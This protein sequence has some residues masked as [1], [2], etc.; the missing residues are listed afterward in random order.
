[1]K[2]YFSILVFILNA[3]LGFS[4]SS[5]QMPGVMSNSTV[6]DRLF[7]E[8]YLWGYSTSNAVGSEKSSID[9]NAI[10]NW[11]TLGYYLS[12]S[13]DGK[14]FSYTVNK[15]TGTLNWFRRLDSLVIQSTHNEWRKAFAGSGPGFFTANGE[16]YV[17]QS[18]EALCLLQL[19]KSQPR[20]VKDVVSYKVSQHG[21]NEW[22][23]WQ[24]KN[25]DSNVVL[26][27]LVT[28][29]ETPF[30][31]VREYNFDNSGEWLVCKLAN[32][33][34]IYNLVTGA[35]RH[36][37][38]VVDY[39]FAPNGKAILLKAIE[40]SGNEITISLKYLG[41]PDWKST[42]IWSTKNER[43]DI[44][45][46]NIDNE[47]R[48][49][50]FTIQ[51]G[52]GTNIWYYNAGMDKAIVKATNGSPGIAAGLAIVS[53]VSF[54]DNGRY[55]KCFIQST[56]DS[57]KPDPDLAQ[58]EVWSH[59]DLYLQSAQAELAKQPKVYAAFINLESG[60]IM[61]LESNGKKLYLL[62][63]DF[64]VVKK[65]PTEEHGDRF[66]ETEKDVNNDSNWLVSLKDGTSKFLP[67][68]A[69]N[70]LFWFSPSGKYLVY[71]DADKGCHFF[72]YDLYTGALK[73]ISPNIPVNQL[74]LVDPYMGRK[75][76]FGNLAAWIEHDAGVLV[77]DNYD[78]WRLD[79][80]GKEPG[81]NITNGF[82]HSNNTVLNL[83]A[84][85][86]YSGNFPVIKANAPLLLQAFNRRNKFNG[87]YRKTDLSAGAPKQLCMGSYFMNAILGCHDVNL[88]NSGMAPVKANDQEIWIVQRQS[89]TE[90]P[91]YFKTTDFIN[92]K[93]LTNFQPQQYFRW[94]S[95]EL[96][97][98]K[99]LDGREG[100]GILYKPADFDSTKKYPVLIAF[101][102]GFSNNLNQFHVP[103]YIDQAMAPGMSP[104]WLVNNG[105]LVFTP[106][107]YTTPLKY[108]PS[109]FNVIEGAAT[110]LKQ[111]PYVDSSKLGCAS[112]SWSA[113]LGAYLFTHSQS[114]NATA[115]SEGFVYAN[116]LNMALSTSNG[117]SRLE[118]VEMEM[119]YGNLYENKEAWLD[120]TTVLQVDK[121]KS[122]L[123]LFCNKESIAAY[124][125]QTQQFFIALRRLDKAVWWLKYENGDHTLSDLKEL[126]DYTIRYTQ[127]FDHYLKE[128]PA[129]LWMTQGLPIT[130]KGV[131]SRY[132]LDPAG[133]CGKGCTIC[134][135]WN[136][137]YKKHPEMFDKPIQEWHLE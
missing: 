13:D 99:H 25:N 126:K 100:Q 40:K 2:L 102:G 118:V 98:F 122:P 33:L 26:H 54:T 127:F 120:Q 34:L 17:F 69:G 88:S 96:H 1:M 91:N 7:L 51:E 22:L 108:G 23:A 132:K 84:T 128:S 137:Q 63:G 10:D 113:K 55:I 90:A 115:I 35:Q 125:D 73:D 30:A 18:G 44:G 130:L 134:K 60:K 117:K 71:F 76:I 57:L 123:L 93:Q 87:F 78:I 121:A 79:L 66:W 101:Y 77:Y 103:T 62:Q 68:S 64:A 36:F 48:Q 72:C 20:I 124:Q 39:A 24:L 135:K 5:N 53:G 56:P 129:P 110:Y 27:N 47:G 111:L 89:G 52:A 29:K 95:E 4:Q 43:N 80:S 107:I 119:E 109:A 85:D 41:A 136:A 86:H 3:A 94:L 104:T 31:G 19:G 49:V 45:S 116:P 6:G 114:F 131:E 97:S 15:P 83:L 67:T 105:Y 8:Q 42:I 32:D 28:G 21:R 50:V 11:R 112:H 16:T 82:G 92:F 65:S 59:K 12:V 106:D 14:Y 61:P 133:S 46:F 74:G 75:P 9:F 37:P 81:I 70:G 38:L 58:V